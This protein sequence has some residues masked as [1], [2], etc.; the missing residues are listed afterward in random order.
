MQ[1][2]AHPQ[3]AKMNA[4]GRVSSGPGMIQIWQVQH[5]PE[6]G[7]DNAALPCMRLALCHE[8]GPVWAAKWCPE[9]QAGESF[10]QSLLTRLDSSSKYKNDFQTLFI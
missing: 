9:A 10:P 1:V 2:G 5:R 6:A 3:N 8:R 7:T 4:A